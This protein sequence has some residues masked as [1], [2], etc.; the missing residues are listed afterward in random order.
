MTRRHLGILLMATLGWAGYATRVHAQQPGAAPAETA[1]QVQALQQSNQQLETELNKL[2]VTSDA[3]AD[4]LVKKQQIIQQLQ[5]TLNAMPAA[6][7]AT[8]EKNN[9]GKTIDQASGKVTDKP[10][11]EK[12]DADKKADDTVK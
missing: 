7:L 10:K 4:A 2:V 1:A 11:P 3:Q 8:F 6:F 9:P 5:A 12:K